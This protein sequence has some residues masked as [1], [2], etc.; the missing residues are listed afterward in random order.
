M[1]SSIPTVQDWGI[2][3][4][5]ELPRERGRRVD[6]AILAGESVVL[7]EFKDFVDTLQAHV[8]QVAAY[9][10]DLSSYQTASHNRSV[11]PVLVKT[12]SEAEPVARGQVWITGATG[13]DRCIER[14]GVVGIRL[15]TCH[16]VAALLVPFDMRDCSAVKPFLIL[17]LGDGRNKIGHL[18]FSRLRSLRHRPPSKAGTGCQFDS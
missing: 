10:R 17:I 5:Y 14:I 3:F 13:L 9:A 2:A 4:E 8:D 1:V 6:V 15:V 7:L 12:P 16:H 11:I 18:I